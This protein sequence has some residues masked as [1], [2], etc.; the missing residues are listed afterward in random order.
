VYWASQNGNAI[1]RAPKAG[2]TPA[3]VVSTPGPTSLLVDAERVYWIS[4]G[5]VKSAP[6]SGGT[7]T[8]LAAASIASDPQGTDTTYGGRL[9]QNTQSLFAY[10]TFVNHNTGVFCTGDAGVVLIPKSGGTPNELWGGYHCHHFN[11]QFLSANGFGADDDYLYVF[12]SGGTEYGLTPGVPCPECSSSSFHGY[13]LGAAPSIDVFG[14]APRSGSST[15][16]LADGN[17]IYFF[18]GG[19]VEAHAC[20]PSSQSLLLDV[21]VT[22]LALDHDYVYWSDG[23]QIGRVAR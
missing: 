1:L 3:V 22:M 4:E 16:V 21:W 17:D 5:S 20:S 11:G 14:G 15:P 12:A 6:S 7:E 9:V 19:L 23:T 18:N 8:V 10:A 13:P 2:G